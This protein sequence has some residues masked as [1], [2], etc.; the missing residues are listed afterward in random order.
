MPSVSAEPTQICESRARYY[1]QNVSSLYFA[2][3]PG[4][5][6][7]ISYC[8]VAY[9]AQAAAPPP[10]GKGKELLN[11]DFMPQARNFA[12]NALDRADCAGL[13]GTEKSRKSGCN[14]V[15]IIKKLFN[16]SGG[17]VGGVTM[18]TYFIPIFP[19]PG[20]A[21]TLKFSSSE[22]TLI[23]GAYGS[24]WNNAGRA[25][26]LS[27]MGLLLLHELGHVYSDTAGKGSGG[28]QIADDGLNLS[29]SG[30]NDALII[31]KCLK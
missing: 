26:D 27:I 8:Q 29:K 10:P 17:S 12:V 1:C 28:S 4:S 25:N 14:P 2:G 31:E 21:V 19:F 20:D 7:L 9:A 16:P 11:W 15:E 24:N 3:V 18:N 22:S 5:F 6:S 23:N 13:F 30:K